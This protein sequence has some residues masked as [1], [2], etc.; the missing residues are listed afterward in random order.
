MAEQTIG[1]ISLAGTWVR[2]G[3]GGFAPGRC[4]RLGARVD[5]QDAPR[6][7]SLAAPDA[8]C[9][10]AKLSLRWVLGGVSASQLASTSADCSSRVGLCLSGFWRISLWRRSQDAL[11][12]VQVDEFGE[13]FSEDATSLGISSSSVAE[14]ALNLQLRAELPEASSYFIRI[15]LLDR[16]KTCCATTPEQPLF[17]D[18]QE[19]AV[20]GHEAEVQEALQIAQSEIS[21]G[22][23]EHAM[24]RLLTAC[25]DPLSNNA[26]MACERAKAVQLGLPSGQ[27]SSVPMPLY[28]GAGSASIAAQ[29]AF[30]PVNEARKCLQTWER[31]YESVGKQLPVNFSTWQH[32]VQPMVFQ[33]A[34]GRRMQQASATDT[35]SSAN[36]TLV[37]TNTNS[38][39][40]VGQTSSFQASATVSVTVGTTNGP[41]STSTTSTT[42]TSTTTTGANLTLIAASPLA[43]LYAGTVEAAAAADSLSKLW[44][45]EVSS[46]AQLL[47]QRLADLKQF[48]RRL[49][50]SAMDAGFDVARMAQAV[51]FKLWARYNEL[52]LNSTAS[53][54][55]KESIISNALQSV[56]NTALFLIGT[57]GNTWIHNFEWSLAAE[58]GDASLPPPSG[59]SLSRAFGGAASPAG[60]VDISDSK[61]RVW[62]PFMEAAEAWLALAQ[63]EVSST[64]A[65]RLA[66]SALTSSPMPSMANVSTVSSSHNKSNATNGSNATNESRNGLSRTAANET[67]ETAGSIASDA[68]PPAESVTSPAAAAEPSKAFVKLVR[69]VQIVI[70]LVERVTEQVLEPLTRKGALLLAGPLPDLLLPNISQVA[71]STCGPRG[72]CFSSAADQFSSVIA[73]ADAWDG[74]GI[75]AVRPWIDPRIEDLRLKRGAEEVVSLGKGRIRLLEELLMLIVDVREAQRENSLAAS[76]AA[77]ARSAAAHMASLITWS[78][79]P[80]SVASGSDRLDASWHY[81]DIW[82]KV[83]GALDEGRGLASRLARRRLGRLERLAAWVSKYQDDGYKVGPASWD[84]RRPWPSWSA[85]SGTGGSSSRLAGAAT[86]A[87][88]QLEQALYATEAFSA[89]RSQAYL[90]IDVRPD[91]LPVAFAGLAQSGTTLLRLQT[92]PGMEHMMMHAEAHVFLISP[93]DV[94]EPLQPSTESGNPHASPLTKPHVELQLRRIEGSYDPSGRLTE[95]PEPSGTRPFITRHERKMCS[96]LENLLV[97]KHTELV[98]GALQPIDGIWELTARDGTSGKFLTIDEGTVLRI[99]LKVDVPVRSPPWKLLSGITDVLYRFPED[100]DCDKLYPIIG[101]AP[102]TSTFP[103]TTRTTI[104]TSTSTVTTVLPK[105]SNEATPVSQPVQS[106][107]QEPAVESSGFLAPGPSP[108]QGIQAQVPAQP[109]ESW[110]PPVWL[111]ILLFFLSLGAC[112]A[113]VLA[114]A[115][116]WKRRRRLAAGKIVPEDADVSEDDKNDTSKELVPEDNKPVTPGLRYRMPSPHKKPEDALATQATG[117]LE[118]RQANPWLPA[119]S[120]RNWEMTD[121]PRQDGAADQH[122]DAQS[123]SDA[124]TPSHSDDDD[125]DDDSPRSSASRGS[126]GSSSSSGHS[127]TSSDTSSSVESPRAALAAKAAANAAALASAREAA[128]TAGTAATGG[129]PFIQNLSFPSRVPAR[130]AD[131]GSKSE[132]QESVLAQPSPEVDTMANKVVEN[133]AEAEDCQATSAAPRQSAELAS[134]QVSSNSSSGSQSERVDPPTTALGQECAGTATNH[135]SPAQVNASSAPAP[136]PPPPLE[137]APPPPEVAAPF[138]PAQRRPAEPSSET[139]EEIW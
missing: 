82:M 127:G 120:A 101:S 104:L 12:G 135:D 35:S 7:R 68:G 74:F 71:I 95:P 14:L 137:A 32:L 8:L 83:R 113:L 88:V 105:T 93:P 36:S 92:P 53:R 84:W 66:E 60:G 85:V 78:A 44:N 28:F 77:Q 94:L 91:V 51:T 40:S 90:R 23:W 3:C 55:D 98:A 115:W 76:A 25:N 22:E 116:W 79:N 122:A 129:S 64:T 132:S 87:F 106:G 48:D 69:I 125:D 33:L 21:T 5:A 52:K 62:A 97:E 11:G 58:V 26:W 114:G 107:K 19:F 111:V 81:Q 73:I 39:G 110:T 61:Q 75:R 43:E 126:H 139:P 46:V 117:E 123:W 108:I 99:L 63:Q 31:V 131:V 1:N 50:Q 133:E 29:S 136:M 45:S 86:A 54:Q 100:G 103:A 16:G 42:T 30:Y 124:S 67:T 70:P 112:T 17:A 27:R 47:P 9:E 121:T 57:W 102:E 128:K 130:T 41:E 119:A 34:A 38:S 89:K 6:C 10:G 49:G 65:R 134:T 37:I 56:G 24:S 80:R 72:G 118:S 20:A 59:F 18:S 15:A 13:W 109:E 4:V 138:P 2:I 96:S